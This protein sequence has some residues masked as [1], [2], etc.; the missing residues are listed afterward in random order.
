MSG[1]IRQDFIAAYIARGTHGN[2]FGGTILPR[3]WLFTG[4]QFKAA[5]IGCKLTVFFYVPAVMKIKLSL[6]SKRHRLGDI[7]PWCCETISGKA[8]PMG[9]VSSYGKPDTSSDGL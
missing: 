6:S 5:L 8:F 9:S 7:V 2:P 1:F 3:G 4:L